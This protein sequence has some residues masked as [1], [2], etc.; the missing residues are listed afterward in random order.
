MTAPSTISRHAL[1]RTVGHVCHWYPDV[2]FPVLEHDQMESWLQEPVDQRH[3]GLNCLPASLPGHEDYRTLQML[4]D[5][6]EEAAM[7]G[8]V[9]ALFHALVAATDEQIV[10]AVPQG[11]DEQDQFHLHLLC[12]GPNHTQK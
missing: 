2:D 7:L 11:G 3:G 6:L 8:Q 1:P 9:C 12:V 5:N 10:L 4:G